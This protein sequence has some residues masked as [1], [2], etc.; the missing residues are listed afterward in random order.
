MPKLKLV[1]VA[2]NL[3]NNGDFIF[4]N[5]FNFK[6]PPAEPGGGLP[7]SKVAQVGEAEDEDGEGAATEAVQEAGQV[8]AEERQARVGG[9]VAW[10]VGHKISP[11]C[12][13]VM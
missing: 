3:Y 2:V 1:S 8:V 6:L 13:V 4:P 12:R 7:S 5:Q 10:I 9:G 11:F